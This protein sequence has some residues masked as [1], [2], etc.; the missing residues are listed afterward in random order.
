M[1]SGSDNTLIVLLLC[2]ARVL[3][4]Y[5][6]CRLAVTLRKCCGKRIDQGRRIT[7]DSEARVARSNLTFAPMSSKRRKLARVNHD[8]SQHR[9]T[10]P[11]IDGLVYTKM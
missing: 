10:A 2:V 8:V 6:E 9:Q 5:L 3:C 4:S 1:G 11:L 7:S